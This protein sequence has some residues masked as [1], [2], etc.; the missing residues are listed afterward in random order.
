MKPELFWIPGPWRGRLAIAARPRG[1]DWLEDEARA[2]REAGLDMV[3]SL[4]ESQEAEQLGLTEEAG[5]AAANGIRFVRFPIPDR[6]VPESVRS[7]GAL[8]ADISEALDSGKNVAVH[9]RQGLGRSGMIAAGV[10]AV[11]GASAE[12]AIEIVSQARGQTVP[13]TPQQRSWIEHLSAG[14]HVPAR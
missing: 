11:S 14:R 12:Q 8:I 2:W 9:C 6:G 5:A 1:A 4:L 3:V 7:A 13:E 10:V